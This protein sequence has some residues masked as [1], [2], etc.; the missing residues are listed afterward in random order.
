MGTT[1]VA[2]FSGHVVDI[3]QNSTVT[4]VHVSNLFAWNSITL[5]K[6]DEEVYVEYVHI[7]HTG[8]CV[9]VGQVVEAGDVI[10]KSGEAGFCPEPH[11]HIQ[12]QHSIADDAPSV[13]I[14]FH[15][16]TF[17][18]GCCYPRE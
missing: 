2:V 9:A 5:K 15:G 8:V 18:A 17:T 11:L 16:D 3:K 7:L 13:P 12:I 14:T 1:L 6:M 4:G 10:G